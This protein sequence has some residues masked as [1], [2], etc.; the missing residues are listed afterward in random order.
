VLVSFFGFKDF[1]RL[2]AVVGYQS[3]SGEEI[4]SWVNYYQNWREHKWDLELHGRSDVMMNV[5]NREM[6]FIFYYS[7]ILNAQK[8]ITNNSILCSSGSFL[9]SSFLSIKKTLK[10]YDT[11]SYSR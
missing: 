8:I 6:H 2:K 10:H 11:F 3:A 7:A 1:G 5:F 9:V 4:I